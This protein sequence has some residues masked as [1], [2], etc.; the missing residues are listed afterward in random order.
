MRLEHN[1]TWSFRQELLIKKIK[2]AEGG[3]V[4][5]GNRFI[6]KFLKIYTEH[7]T[8]LRGH[9]AEVRLYKYGLCKAVASHSVLHWYNECAGWFSHYELFTVQTGLQ[10]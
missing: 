2:D 6:L 9:M 3:L 4:K 10:L 7:E 5:S 1:F 8:L